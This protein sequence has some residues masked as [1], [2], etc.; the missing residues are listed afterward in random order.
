M[1]KCNLS[2]SD[3]SE[4]GGIRAIAEASHMGD[5]HGS[6]AKNWRRLA[7]LLPVAFDF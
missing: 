6:N 2:K 3:S 4:D 1:E 7:T 5:G